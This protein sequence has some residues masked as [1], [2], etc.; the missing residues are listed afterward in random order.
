MTIVGGLRHR[1]IR[2]SLFS[3]IRTSLE[4]LGWFDT[5]R[6]HGPIDFRTIPVPED[7]EVPFNTCVVSCDDLIESDEEMGSRLA[8][9]VWTG[10]VDFYAE[11]DAVGLH[12]IG[13]I[14]DL[15]AGRMS[16]IG[17][18]GPF[19]DV[20]NYEEATPS[21]I[22]RCQIEDIVVDRAHGF[23]KPYQR[24]WYACRFSI[25]DYYGDENDD[26]CPPI[27]VDFSSF[28]DGPLPTMFDDTTPWITPFG[29]TD[30]SISGGLA[31]YDGFSLI[32]QTIGVQLPA[33]CDTAIYLEITSTTPDDGFGVVVA[34]NDLSSGYVIGFGLANN[35]NV[36]GIF[37]IPPLPPDEDPIVL[38]PGTDPEGEP[39]TLRI[40]LEADGTVHLVQIV[41][42]NEIYLGN[43]MTDLDFQNS[44]LVGYVADVFTSYSSFEI[45]CTEDIPS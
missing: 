6:F 9:H 7:E 32:G 36:G 43:Y 1:F 24:H 23:P 16:N 30:W 31:I 14:K 29:L 4:D 13:D 35:V 2:D 17:R 45:G 44:H 15:L 41:N 33:C 10:W 28:T 19:F 27:I 3:M 11:S 38:F 25:F 20:Y 21:Q 8:E 5:G 37:Q 26:D 42:D 18:T 12:F 22:F 34:P 39:V 40:V